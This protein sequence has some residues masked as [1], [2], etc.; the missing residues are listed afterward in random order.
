MLLKAKE[1]LNA[2]KHS[3]PRDDLSIITDHTSKL[4]RAH[5][6]LSLKWLQLLLCINYK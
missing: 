3:K 5:V 6:R 1:F 4:K 2:L